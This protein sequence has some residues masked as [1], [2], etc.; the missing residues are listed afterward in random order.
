MDIGRL[1]SLL[2]KTLT[3]RRVVRIAIIAALYAVITLLIAPIA[4]NALQFR[5]SEAIKVFVLFDP[6][7]A[8]G[9]GIGTFISNLASPNG[10]LDLT[11][12][13]LT[14]ILGGLLVWAV[15]KL[16]LRRKAPALAMALYALTTS[17]AVSAMLAILGVDAFLVLFPPILFSEL[18]IMAPAT[19]LIFWIKR[20][21]QARGI[22]LE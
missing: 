22:E 18:V 20:Q 16:L 2:M 10:P 14:D 19:P 1:Q 11:L 17:L 13:P 6:W 8:V 12:M 9:I 4:Y 5:I 15:Y 21:L 3:T 7:L